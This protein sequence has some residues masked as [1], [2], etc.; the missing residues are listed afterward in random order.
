V[1]RFPSRVLVAAAVLWPL[2]LLAHEVPIGDRGYIMETPGVLFGPFVY[3]GAK[4]MLTGLDHLL[5]LLG[6]IFWLYR[7]K[8][9]ALYVTLFAVGHSLTLIA[10]T[11][12]NISVNE[13]VIDGIIGLSVAYKAAEN[14]GWFQRWLGW[15]PDARAA[16]LL[17][18]LAH[19]LGLATRLQTFELAPDSLLANLLAFNVGVEFGQLLGLGAMLMLIQWW[20][21]RPG[22]DTQARRGNL[23]LLVVG[24]WLAGVQLARYAQPTTS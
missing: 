5:F 4:H 7:A 10:G 23:V 9:V 6:V 22:F 19:G 14:L 8:D 3:L 2:P 12:F 16:T 24:L 18:G 15:Q 11:R 20:R 17:F 21:T 13:H 1:T